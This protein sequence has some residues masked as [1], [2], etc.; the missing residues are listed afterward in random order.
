MQSHDRIFRRMSRCFG[1]FPNKTHSN[2]ILN[3]V[4]VL[5]TYVEVSGRA[6]NVHKACSYLTRRVPIRRF[7]LANIRSCDSGVN[8][9]L[10]RFT[11][12]QFT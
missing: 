11:S 1:I 7:T 4:N 12:Y 2:G 6:F 10:A 9:I 5:N 3:G 8:S